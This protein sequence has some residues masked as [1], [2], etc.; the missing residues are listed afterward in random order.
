MSV[1]LVA[2]P[3]TLEQ[4]PPIGSAL[5]SVLFVSSDSRMRLSSSTRAVIAHDP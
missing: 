5:V 4:V 2:A 3:D 1:K